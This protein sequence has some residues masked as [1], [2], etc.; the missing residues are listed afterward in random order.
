MQFEHIDYFTCKLP[1]VVLLSNIKTCGSIYN[2]LLL[3]VVIAF[4]AIHGIH[5]IW[6]FTCQVRRI[7]TVDT[8]QKI[9]A[10]MLP[11]KK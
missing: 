2:T 9:P 4:Y 1:A 6:T 8:L 7:P 3:F 11:K 5:V 10:P